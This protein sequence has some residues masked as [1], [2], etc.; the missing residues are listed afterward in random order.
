MAE[1]T[2][3]S[4]KPLLRT[5]KD[6]EVLTIFFGGCGEFGMNATGYYH[7]GRLWLVDCGLVFSEPFQLGVESGIPA[8][9]SWIE[10]LGGIHAYLITHGHEDHIGALPYFLAKWNAPVYG[11]EWTLSL[12]REKTARQR[13]G[14]IDLRSV[15]GG[16]SII[17]GDLRHRWVHVNHSIPMAC[18][19]VLDFSSRRIFHTGDFKIEPD[20]PYDKPYD[21]AE[22]KSIGD[23]GIDLLVSDSTNATTQGHCP[24]ESTVIPVLERVISQSPG[25]TFF[26]TFSSNLW[27]IRSVID[28]CRK[29]GRPVAISGAGIKKVI[30]LGLEHNLLGDISHL[31]SEEDATRMNAKDLVVLISGCQGE[32]RAALTRLIQG[33]HAHFQLN[34]DDT[35]VFSSRVIPGNEKS[36]LKLINR[37]VAQNIRVVS[38]RHEPGI[39]VSGHAY[40]EE[41]KILLNSLQPR[42][43]IPVH[44]NFAHLKANA[45]LSDQKSIHTL[46]VQ[47][48]SVIKLGAKGAEDL[49]VIEI[50]RDFVDSWSML[51]ISYET[52]RDRL[53]I[54]ENGLAVLS[55]VFSTFEGHWLSGPSLQVIGLPRPRGAKDDQSWQKHIEKELKQIMERTAG[56]DPDTWQEQLRVS[57]RR[58]LA[59]HFVKKPVVISVV[60]FV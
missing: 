30:Q 45:S 28:V 31:A 42:S 39:H 11:T 33:E 22:L 21:L 32:Y 58:F 54:G 50:Q 4:L 1:P 29:L 17:D 51:P 55:G 37:C 34:P 59:D 19:L 23:L 46:D 18:S 44:G 27:R 35:I 20:N 52:L 7:R 26:T 15:K 38:S 2:L 24:G 60:Q 3:P 36:V 56:G 13:L 48:G 43:Y 57:T 41:L 9:D 8:I 49:G 5:L 53:R 25:R 12:I 14:G 47:N 16:D 10:E 6:D 40:Q